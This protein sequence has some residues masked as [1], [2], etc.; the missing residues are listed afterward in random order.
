MIGCTTCRF[1][2]KRPGRDLKLRIARAIGDKCGKTYYPGL[3]SLESSLCAR[4]PA[5]D[6]YD[7]TRKLYGAISEAR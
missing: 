6:S 5:T 3:A 2:R 4:V 7:V 1:L